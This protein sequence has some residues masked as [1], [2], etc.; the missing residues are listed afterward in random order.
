MRN[1]AIINA[2]QVSTG[3]HFG[4]FYTYKAILE[5]GLKAEWY[6][7][8]DPGHKQQFFL[9]G[10]TIKGIYLPS[11][12]L[13][14][15]M[16][17]L[18]IFPRRIP[19]LSGN[20]VLLGDPTLLDMTNKVERAW[21]KVHDLR[22]FTS[23]G[24][25]F[26]TKIMFRHM[27]PKLSRVERVLVTTQEMKLEVEKIGIEKDKIFV[28][29]DAI[30]PEYS[31]VNGPAHIER[32]IGKMTEQGV[33]DFL[34]IAQDRLYKNINLFLN[35][36]R[37]FSDKNTGIQ[38]RFNLVSTIKDNTKK[39]IDSLNLQNL[40][41][42]SNLKDLNSIY[43]NSDILLF[44]SLYEGF[45]RP[46]IEAMSYGIPV[47]AHNIQ[48]IIEITDG[49]SKLVGVND[50]QSWKESILSLLDPESYR[51]YGLRSWKR[52]KYFSWDLFKERV[53]TVFA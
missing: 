6:Q 11:L 29:Y 24:D 50:L 51:E 46:V 25:K 32:S 5:I 35:V 30:P 44:P 23:Y 37:Y 12:E 13:E 28:L 7:C 38:M 21:V 39:I 19:D 45:G 40:T 33:V 17:R 48:P 9:E 42:Y 27:L 49:A 36:A 34:Y 52:S 16:N 14:M 1:V 53:K 41:V 3:I 18:L 43:E 8:I 20:T 22:P 26:W 4:I 10:H 2:S 31:N 47:I 15:G